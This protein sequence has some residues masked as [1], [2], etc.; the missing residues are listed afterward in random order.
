MPN[1]TAGGL[2]GGFRFEGSGPG[3]CNC[4]FANN[5]PYALG[6]RVGVAYQITPKTVFRAGWGLIYGQT[7]T[8]PLGINAAGI[9]N[10]FIIGSPG[11]GQP[12][13]QLQDGIPF[14]PQWPLTNPGVLPAQPFGNQA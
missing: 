12:A 14:T 8:N 13:L 2:P 6:P 1:P 4:Q 9:A 10:N 7:S 5:Y 3:H 11:L